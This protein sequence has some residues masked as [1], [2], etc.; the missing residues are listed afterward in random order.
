MFHGI[1]VPDMRHN[2][3][4]D[5]SKP[6]CLERNVYQIPDIFLPVGNFVVSSR[7]KEKLEGLPNIAFLPVRFSRLFS[8]PFRAGDFSYFQTDSFLQDPVEYAPEKFFARQ[9]NSPSLH[10]SVGEYYEV[11][12]PRLNDI[13]ARY[14]HLKRYRYLFEFAVVNS[15]LELELSPELLRDHPAVWQFWNVLSEDVYR[16]MLPYFNWD[17]FEMQESEI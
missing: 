9:E 12:V 14:H 11:I 3:G 17:Y 5:L 2:L 16:R 10:S 15:E 13:K 6:L 4:G 7:V 1:S 8:F